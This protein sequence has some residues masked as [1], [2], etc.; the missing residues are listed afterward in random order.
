M[1]TLD[2]NDDSPVAAA[3]LRRHLRDHLDG[4]LQGRSFEIARNG[5][6]VALLGPPDAATLVVAN[7]EVAD[8]R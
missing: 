5:R 4:V 3:E 6:V 2:M 8:G 1:Y 7:E